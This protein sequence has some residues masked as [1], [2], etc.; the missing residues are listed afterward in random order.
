MKMK[1]YIIY[2]LIPFLFACGGTKTHRSS[3]FDE[4][5]AKDTR[6]LD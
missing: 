4:A 6:G 3:Q 5:F 2:A 1:K